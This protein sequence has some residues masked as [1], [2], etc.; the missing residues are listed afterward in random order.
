[1]TLSR[2][3]FLMVPL[4]SWPTRDS[5]ISMTWLRSASRTFCTMTCFAVCAA[6]RPNS[7]DSTGTSWNWPISSAGS[8]SCAWSGV[9]SESGSETSSA[10]RHHGGSGS[11][12]SSRC[13][14]ITSQ[15]RKVS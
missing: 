6:M 8:I 3:V 11:S 15:Q 13:G 7:T 5:Y 4:T 12:S 10:T 2:E 9:S 14:S 1:M